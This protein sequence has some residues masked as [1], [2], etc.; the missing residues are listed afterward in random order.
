MRNSW[1]IALQTFDTQ[2][3]VQPWIFY[4]TKTK[5]SICLS[6]TKHISDHKILVA[7]QC[8]EHVILIFN[9]F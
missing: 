5:T 2:L 9:H 3:I 7:L 6:S 8:F 1:M 4:E